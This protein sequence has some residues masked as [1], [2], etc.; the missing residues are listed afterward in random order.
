MNNSSKH[1]FSKDGSS[2]LYSN[3][4]GQF[5]HNPN[6]AIS[7]SKYVFFDAPGLTTAFDTEQD[8]LIIFEIGFGT[9]LNFM[10]LLDQY[11]SKNL[12]FPVHFY[13]VES[14]PVTEETANTFNF[15]EFL[16]HQELKEILP[17]IFRQL[18]PGK[19]TFH[20]LP[21]KNVRLHLFYSTFD[22]VKSIDHA[23]NFVFQDAFSPEVN[24]ELWTVGAFE[25]LASFCADD[26]VM[27]TYCAASKARAAM[28]KAGW[29]IGRTQGALGKREMTIASLSEKKL[30]SFKR[31]NEQRLIERLESGDF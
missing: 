3:K 4:F 30:T 18:R 29:F 15:F 6:G 5:Y 27:A 17:N 7:E 19:N 21:N 25:K 2:T 26:A 9:G 16:E 8:Q 20:P 28:A 31:V 11:L 12:T 24:K 22:E 23:A 1:H 10:L 13:S 14:F